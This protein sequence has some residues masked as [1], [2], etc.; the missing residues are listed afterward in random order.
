[1][2]KLAEAGIIYIDDSAIYV[3]DKSL[4]QSATEF[5]RAVIGHVQSLIDSGSEAEAGWFDTPTFEE[6]LLKV[7][8]QWM[9]HRVNSEWHEAPFWELCEEPGRGHRPVWYIDFEEELNITNRE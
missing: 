2:G 3:A 4:Y 5:L 8:T 9:V 6:E 7:C 1:M